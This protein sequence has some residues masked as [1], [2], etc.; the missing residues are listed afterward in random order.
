MA[1]MPKHSYFEVQINGN[2]KTKFPAT[3]S[4]PIPILI[5]DMQFS[6]YQGAGNDFI[7]IDARQSLPFALDGY[8]T[9]KKLCNR[10]FGIGADGLML[11]RNKAGYDFEMLYYNSDGH[12]STMCGNGGRCIVAFAKALGIEKQQY[13]FL[14]VDGPHHAEIWP[15]GHVALSMSDVSNIQRVG[16]DYVLDTGSPHYVSYVKDCQQVD[17][18]K[19]ARA[20]RYGDAFAREGINVNFVENK[21]NDLTLRTYERGV[22]GETLACGTGVTAAAI[23]LALEQ[24]LALGASF[25]YP[26]QASGGTLRVQGK[27][28][29]EGFVNLV[30][31]GPAEKVFEGLIP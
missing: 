19:E 15:G 20:I 1:V 5:L 26:V 4:N 18:I 14:A 27:R 17:I 22:E 31:I 16:N 21:A 8:K 6:K 9:I 24:N 3:I 28:T 30:L 29:V 25:D 23:T 12:P 2:E 7:L 11:L 13:Y 10:H